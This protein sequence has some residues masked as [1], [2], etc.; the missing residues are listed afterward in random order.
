MTRTRVHGPRTTRDAGNHVTRHAHGR[1]HGHGHGHGRV[2]H[3][4]GRGRGRG[5]GHVGHVTSDT[6]TLTRGREH[7]DVTD[8]SLSEVKRGRETGMDAD[9]RT[10][11]SE[12]R[13]P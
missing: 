10:R 1:G 7:A 11:T 4:R 12:H 2:Q 9:L 6:D 5:H 13:R 8:S 3:G